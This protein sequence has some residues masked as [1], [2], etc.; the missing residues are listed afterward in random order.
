VLGALGH[1]KHVDRKG[2]GSVLPTV[3]ELEG[4][5]VASR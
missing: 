3:T 4:Q 1:G 2:R 5:S